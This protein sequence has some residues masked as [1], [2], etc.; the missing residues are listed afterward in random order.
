MDVGVS[1]NYGPKRQ[2]AGDG[3]VVKGKFSANVPTALE[4]FV[5][6]PSMPE[7]AWW[8]DVVDDSSLYRQAVKLDRVNVD[9]VFFA[10]RVF[11]LKQHSLGRTA[12][13]HQFVGSTDDLVQVATVRNFGRQLFGFV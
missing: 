5:A 9:V 10:F 13:V 6:S 1:P 7:I 12:E 11:L 3:G 4:D 2:L 8:Q